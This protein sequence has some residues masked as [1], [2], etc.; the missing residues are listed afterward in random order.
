MEQSIK[1]FDRLVEG[2]RFHK[3]G[4]MCDGCDKPHEDD[5]IFWKDGIYLCVNCLEEEKHDAY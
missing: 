4:H 1:L 5:L 2:T 3:K